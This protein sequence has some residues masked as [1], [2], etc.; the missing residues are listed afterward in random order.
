MMSRLVITGLVL[1]VGVIALTIAQMHALDHGIDGTIYSLYL[2]V[3]AGLVSGFC[4][5]SIKEALDWWKGR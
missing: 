1:V 5:F 4:G 2:L 3:V